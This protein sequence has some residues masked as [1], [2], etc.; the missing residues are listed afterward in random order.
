MSDG[1]AATV[2]RLER[3]ATVMSTLLVLGLL[4]VLIWDAAH[5]NT[6]PRFVTHPASMT[7]ASGVFRT[8][9]SVRNLGDDPAKA[10]VVHVE[11]VAADSVLSETDIVIDWLPG[12]SSR[13]VVGWFTRRATG[14]S[15]TGVRAEV[16]G[17]A[18]P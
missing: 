9:V 14:P 18:T 4:S 10:V 5:P 6:Q 17:Y 1:A 13:E 15:P 16:R 3:V 2:G 7:V 11:L 12:N 8:P